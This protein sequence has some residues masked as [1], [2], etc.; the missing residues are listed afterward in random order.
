MKSTQS[1]NISN[2]NS[3]TVQVVGM[4]LKPVLKELNILSNSKLLYSQNEGAMSRLWEFWQIEES[5][6]EKLDTLDRDEENKLIFKFDADWYAPDLEIDDNFRNLTRLSYGCANCEFIIA[7]NPINCFFYNNNQYSYQNLLEYF[8]CELD[9]YNSR[10]IIRMCIL[11][12]ESNN[13]SLVDLFFTFQ[14]R[15]V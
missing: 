11:I 1:E 2:R 4:N 10:N 9:E 8:H 7:G 13:I 5:A 12:A 15:G 3:N 14:K 6:W